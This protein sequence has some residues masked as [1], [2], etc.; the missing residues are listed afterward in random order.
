MRL[1]SKIKASL[2][3]A[4]LLPAISNAVRPVER[5]NILFILADDLGYGDL[6]CYGN[7]VIQTPVIDKL[8][9]ESMHFTNAYAGASVSSPSRCCL[10]TGMH[11]GHGRIRGNMCK[12]GG[13]QVEREGM[14][15]LVRRTNLQPEDVTIAEV[16]QKQGYR[17]CLVNK[18]HLDGFDSTATPM[19]RGFDEFYG[20]LIPEPNSQ[21]Y[22]PSVRWRNREKYTIEANLNG[23]HRDHNTDRSTDEA[24][25]FMERMGQKQPFFLYLAY[26]APH[27]P[28]DAKDRKLYLNSGLPVVDQS[29]AALVSH[30]DE[31]IGRVLAKLKE[32]GLDKNTLVVFA[33]DNGGATAAEVKELK[34]NGILRGFK[35]ELWEGG[36]RVPMMV[37]WPNHIKPG[38]ASNQPCY[39]PDFFPTFAKLAGVTQKF[40]T[41]GTDLMPAWKGKK[42]PNRMLYW[43]QFPRTGLSQAVRFGDWKAIRM[44]LD[45]PWMLFNLKNDPSE[46]T[47]IAAQNPKVIAQIKDYISTARTESECWPVD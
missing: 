11:T 27:V 4:A 29:Y 24:I 17:T 26:N 6:G 47:D 32:L 46:T 21:N 16:L 19:D 40:V 12:V 13:L 42:L 45:K 18:W 7:K 31:N 22:Y 36:I 3:L 20:W 8:C 44:N 41:D 9:R 10:M 39:F 25:R 38:T 33:S 15:G 23:Q 37:R 43:E 28:L 35:G 34:L 14:P 5:P 1:T 2:G 30:M